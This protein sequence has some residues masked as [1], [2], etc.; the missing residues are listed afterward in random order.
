[1]PGRLVKAA[2]VADS[3]VSGHDLGQ[4]LQV[5][6][7]KPPGTPG[8]RSP[9]EMPVEVQAA[10]GADDDGGRATQFGDLGPDGRL[11]LGNG[12]EV[13]IAVQADGLAS[14]LLVPGRGTL[15]DRSDAEEHAAA[16]A[17]VLADEFENAI[18]VAGEQDRLEPRLVQIS[19]IVRQRLEED[20]LFGMT[21]QRL[22]ELK[23]GNVLFLATMT[24]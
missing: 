9:P 10:A 15:V 23:R 22:E 19:R 2:D 8:C 24:M 7:D 4:S 5:D 16:V 20:R 13:E 21:K 17:I 14:G 11:V 6:L 18:D 1:M 12:L 3:R